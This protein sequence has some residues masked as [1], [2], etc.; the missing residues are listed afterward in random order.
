M[1]KRQRRKAREADT[2]PATPER[3]RLGAPGPYMVCGLCGEPANQVTFIN[4]DTGEETEIG[5]T[6]ALEIVDNH[7]NIIK[8]G[9]NYGHEALPVEGNPVDADGGCDFCYAPDPRWVFVPRKPIVVHDPSDGTEA[10]YSSPWSC[11]DGCLPAVKS[12]NLTRMV[13]RAIASSHS[14]VLSDLTTAE[15]ERYRV[16]VGK[17]Y[18]AYLKSIPAGPYELKIPGPRKPVGKRGSLRGTGR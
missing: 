8:S 11:C 13:D 10:D 18:A 15:R 2:E 5:Y 17:L 9:K 12:K 1:G 7:G 6:H 3:P 14:A 16:A 4:H